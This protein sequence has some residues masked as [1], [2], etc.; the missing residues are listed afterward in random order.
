MRY[1]VDFDYRGRRMT[2]WGDFRKASPR[3]Q[4]VLDSTLKAVLQSFMDQTKILIAGKEASI[5]KVVETLASPKTFAK[6]YHRRGGAI[7]VPRP[8]LK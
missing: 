2:S 8:Y 1:I 6:I 4:T 3:L 7:L 5:V